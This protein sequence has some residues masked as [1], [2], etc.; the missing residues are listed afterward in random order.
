VLGIKDWYDLMLKP[1][2]FSR[3]VTGCHPSRFGVKN[4]LRATIKGSTDGMIRKAFIMLLK[5]GYQGEYRQRHLSVW[6]ELQ[7]GLSR[8][9]VHNYSI[10]LDRDT[11]KLF[12]YVEIES[13][14]L[15]QQIAET[16]A[17]R[18]WWAYMQ[19]MRLTHADNSPVAIELDE[20]FHLD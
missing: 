4:D 16:E 14:A 8:H 17:C 2:I 7:T 20:V 6:P 1:A 12:A 19:E 11:D 5:P 15:W 9:G 13:E 3:E 10:F 18:R